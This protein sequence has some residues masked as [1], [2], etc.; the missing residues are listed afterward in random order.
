MQS[1]DE[2]GYVSKHAQSKVPKWN[3]KNL[4]LILDG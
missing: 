3:E 1:L 4:E 2:I